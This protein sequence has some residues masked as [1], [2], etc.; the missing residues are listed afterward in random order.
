MQ[1]YDRRA[2]GKTKTKSSFFRRK[3]RLKHALLLGRRQSGTAVRN[4]DYHAAFIGG[5]RADRNCASRRRNVFHSVHRIDEEIEKDLLQLD[6]VAADL[7]Q[8]S[9]LRT[10]DGNS[11]VNELAVEQPKS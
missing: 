3:E 2:Y 11:P 4:A 1:F 8:M 5:R 7:R 10:V 6:G 9:D